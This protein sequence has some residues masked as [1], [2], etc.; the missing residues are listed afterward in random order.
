MPGIMITLPT[1][2]T[3]TSVLVDARDADSPLLLEVTQAYL[4]YWHVQCQAYLDR[5]PSLLPEV[6]GPPELARAEGYIAQLNAEGRAL[7]CDVEHHII[8]LQITEA[9][10]L[11]YDE[12]LNRSLNVDPVTKQPLPSS[13]PPMVLRIFHSMQKSD[14]VW[15]VVERVRQ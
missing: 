10:A 6:I 5:N 11:I 9:T 1:T 4:R 8:I 7:K 13:D 14:S 2:P 12:Y 15:R 3:A